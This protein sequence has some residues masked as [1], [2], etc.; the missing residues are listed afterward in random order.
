[1]RH[2][3][4]IMTDGSKYRLKD[5]IW[6]SL[7][8]IFI[9]ASF[10]IGVSVEKYRLKSLS[11][12]QT[13]S[14]NFPQINVV[15]TS[16]D[17]QVKEVD[18]D[19][20]WTVWKRLQA[21]YIGKPVQDSTL[22]YGS[23]AGLAASLDDPYSVFLPPQKAERFSQ[24]LSGS[25]FG[26]GAEIGVKGGVITVIAPL[27][28]SPAEKT[29]IKAG[30]KIFKINDEET[31][32]LTLDDAVNKIRGP[33]GTTVKL[34]IIREGLSAPKDFSIVRDVIKIKSVIW[35]M[36][37]RK[38]GGKETV[39]YIK[40]SNFNE[41]TAEAFDQAVR[42]VLGK[43]AASIVLDLRNNPGGFLDTAVRLASEWVTNG[44]IVIEKFSDGRKETYKR[45]G[46]S[47][48]SGL[49]TIVLVNQGSASASEIVAGALQDYGQA[50]V[51]G[52]KTFGKG[53][54][55]DYEQFPDGSGLKITIAE[56]L[57]PKGR[58]INKNGIA[59]DKLVSAEP[60]KPKEEVKLE[61]KKEET[62]EDL[63][64][65]KALEMLK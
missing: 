15:R 40:I 32:N 28:D 43:N 61:V 3:K 59:P 51:I 24:D 9:A 46:P 37:A 14:L 27:P 48:L 25:F 54:V 62:P 30:D 29:G 23:L 55:Q 36:M 58:A 19:L 12:A 34:T 1:M 20:Y 8:L 10:F 17:S 7:I 41:D 4:I 31:T 52:E 49:K 45:N 56:W 63:V 22:F 6:P 21:K 57:T 5:F 18:F 11:E 2:F 13:Q 33:Q 64:L 44:P 26:I 60:E 16:S 53:S 42:G 35:K 50:T 47:R 65:Q 38:T 39:G